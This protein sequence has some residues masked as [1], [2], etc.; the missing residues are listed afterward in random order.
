MPGLVKIGK[1]KKVPT[2]RAKELED[3]GVPK[4]YL[5]SYIPVYPDV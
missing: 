4:P 2:E 1:S 5:T 3:T